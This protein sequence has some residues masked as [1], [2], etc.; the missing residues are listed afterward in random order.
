MTKREKRL[1]DL[2]NK[3]ARMEAERTLAIKTLVKIENDLP[4]L[5]KQEYRLTQSLERRAAELRRLSQLGPFPGEDITE[6]KQ[7]LDKAVDDAL[8][9]IPTFLD[10]TAAGKAKDDA[11]RAEILAAQAD[12]KKH[13]NAR[14]IEKMKIAQEV[15]HAELTGA[16]RKMP[17]EGKAALEAIRNGS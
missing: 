15:K 6:T 17:L 2:R 13:K 8:E 11:A 7:M 9:D 5:R 3:I 4:G 16:R 1:R 10:R 12:D 14:R